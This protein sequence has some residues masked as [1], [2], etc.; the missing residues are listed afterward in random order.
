MSILILGNDLEDKVKQV[1]YG[2]G[3]SGV[4]I[5][6]K[7]LEKCQTNFANG[8]VENTQTGTPLAITDTFTTVG[9]PTGIATE[10][11]DSV[12]SEIFVTVRKDGSMKDV[13]LFG[14]VGTNGSF[15][16]GSAIWYTSG[17]VCEAFNMSDGN[18]QQSAKAISATTTP[19]GDYLLSAAFSPSGTTF[20]NHT[21]GEVVTAAYPAGA[22]AR[23]IGK[24]HYFGRHKTGGVFT[25][26]AKVMQGV[27][28]SRALTD[29]ERN[30]IVGYMRSYAAKR[31]VTV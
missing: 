30:K 17:G 31:G 20:R 22:P 12:N 15:A 4:F 19:S 27:V 13:I 28:V 29:S 9:S 8:A 24:Y 25:G 16:T 2:V 11:T 21:T 5:L 14:T 3:E 26:T 7:S 1:N 6:N 10:V 23:T 18:Y